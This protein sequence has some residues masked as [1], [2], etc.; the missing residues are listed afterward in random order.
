[1]NVDQAYAFIKGSAEANRL[2]QAYVVTAPPRGVGDV[3]TMRILSL[4]FCSE[5]GEPCGQCRGC[6]SAQDRTHPDVHWIEP[7]KKSRI[8]SVEQMRDI[9]TKIFSTSFSGGWKVCILVGADCLRAAAAN[10]FLKT[11]EEPPK[12][13][14]FLLLTDSPQS[15]LPTII[16]RCQRIA[17]T[18]TDGDGLTDELRASVVD[19]LADPTAEF[20]VGGL[21]KGDRLVGLLKTVR[22]G[23]E[24]E[25][26]DLLEGEQTETDSVTLDAR[27]SSRYREKRQS[28]M[29]SVLLWYRDILLLTCEADSKWVHHE[30]SQ[31]MLREV[32][33][34][35]SYREAM[36]QVRA[37]EKMNQ[38][39]AMNMPELVVFSSGFSAVG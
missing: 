9:Q 39:L 27:I 13:T 12:K 16:S 21:A 36:A 29:R 11:L 34:C 28:V 19:I 33:A 2:A 38:Q 4:L 3:L 26:K 32:A 30:V 6:I 18:G 15:L 37:V 5:E 14:L 31:E 25:E 24:A 8:I 17:V 20:M 1:M 10:A 35:T 7:Q 22:S 23:I